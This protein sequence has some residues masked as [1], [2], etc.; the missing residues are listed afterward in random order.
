MRGKKLNLQCNVP[1]DSLLLLLDCVEP[2]VP[3]I[4]SKSFN[5]GNINFE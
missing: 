5:K 1:Q 4:Q 2:R 3:E